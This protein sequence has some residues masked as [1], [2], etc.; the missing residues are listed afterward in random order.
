M[1]YAIL[2]TIAMVIVGNVPSVTGQEID[3][4]GAFPPGPNRNG[5]PDLHTAEVD[6]FEKPDKPDETTAKVI[7][8][9]PIL[10]KTDAVIVV[11][12]A[13]WC[14]ACKRQVL[15]LKGP[16]NRYNVLVY[17][18]EKDGEELA[19]LLKIGRSIPVIMVLEK[20]KPTKTFIGYTPWTQ[21]KPHAKKAVKNE[22]KG[23]I[24]IGPIR[25]DWDLDGYD[26]DQYRRRR[27]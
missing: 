14:T 6:L 8:A 26:S 5:G 27:N 22:Q 13:E 15:E 23:S 9:Y 20:G 19:E 16:S 24:I 21:I 18:V 4:M 11:F 12:G 17:D 7:K 3:R 10:A 1:K 25:I 2:L